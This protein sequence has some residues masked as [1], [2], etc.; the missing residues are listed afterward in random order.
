MADNDFR[1]AFGAAFPDG[2]VNS[3]AQPNKAV[4]R[5]LGPLIDAALAALASLIGSGIQWKDPVAV[6]TT[7]NVTLSGEQTIDGVQTSA[8]RVLVK[9]QTAPAQ[10]GI[11]VTG[12][13]AWGR[14]ADADSAAEIKG[15]AVFV[16][17]GTASK[18]KQFVCLATGVISLGST[19]LPYV[20][21]SDQTALNAAIVDLQSKLAE[22]FTAN[23]PLIDDRSNLIGLGPSLY[24]P[25]SLYVPGTLQYDL[26]SNND[27]LASWYRVAVPVTNENVSVYFD[28]QTN[29]V[30][31]VAYP[32]VNP[33]DVNRYYH[34]ISFFGGDKGYSTRLRY[35]ST[36]NTRTVIVGCDTPIVFDHAAGMLKVPVVYGFT[37]A[38]GPW[39]LQPVIE[40]DGYREIPVDK[41]PADTSV[42][43]VWIDVADLIRNGPRS[44]TAL[45][46]AKGYDATTNPMPEGAF[47]VFLGTILNETFH[48]APSS[49]SPVAHILP[50]NCGS[51][52]ADNDQASFKYNSTRPVDLKTSAAKSMGFTRAFAASDVESGLYRT[53]YGDCFDTRVKSGIVYFR[54]YI[55]TD[56]EGLYGDGFNAFAIDVNDSASNR[57]LMT[58]IKVRSVRKIGTGDFVREFEGWYRLPPGGVNA[59]TFQGCWI[60]FDT[61]VKDAVR[62]FGL[63]FAWSLDG[64]PYVSLGDYPRKSSTLGNRLRA[65][66]SG[67][68]SFDSL[69]EPVIPD[70]LYLIDGREY[71]LFPAQMIDDIAADRGRFRF[72]LSTDPVGGD[73]RKP[74]NLRGG[75]TS[76]LV[77]KPTDFENQ[78]VRLDFI[79][80]YGP[81]G[82]QKSRKI[83]VRKVPQDNII[84][85]TKKVLV[86][87][88]SIG[89]WNGSVT[90]SIHRLNS[91]GAAITTIGTLEMRGYIPGD[92][93]LLG[94]ARGGKEFSDFIYM[95]T[96][97]MSPVTNTTAGVN[98][99]LA[100]ADEGEYTGKRMKNPFVRPSTGGDPADRI[101]NGYIFDMRF[102]LNR[103]GFA[104]PD[105]VYIG[106]GTNDIS[107]QYANPTLALQQIMNGVRVMT[108]Q[109]RAALPNAKIIFSWHSL[110]RNEDGRWQAVHL[111]FLRSVLQYLRALND[112]NVYVLP[113]YCSVNRDTGHAT[114]GTVDATG[115]ETNNT[116]DGIHY[117]YS[118][119]DQFAEISAAFFA[120][121]L[122]NAG[123]N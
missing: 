94:E 1:N 111:K 95:D 112:P 33:V 110:G 71:T 30:K 2:P 53:Y 116:Y 25:R 34:I 106:L 16:R 60:G 10:N 83:K 97:H 55:E 27:R 89:D 9:N 77:L 49:H 90:R 103:F 88:D 76:S 98:A 47:C 50:N 11:Y 109:T 87:A 113:A 45:H 72:A 54:F 114:G 31:V 59:Q 23:G 48:P 99:Y 117:N 63:Q 123:G 101:F 68:A 12:A 4:I 121:V 19:P 44:P 107:Q 69:F 20:E 100:L 21:I 85:L 13:G 32:N 56:L 122:T 28:L 64:F 36:G 73:Y 42:K 67:G 24:I 26:P 105:A 52:A 62:I 5:S 81:Q 115:L 92:P 57:V 7:G 61:T 51:G 14:A 102:Y 35:Q 41:T 18:G 15:M 39:L 46:A 58:P 74:V 38:G 79:D 17:G 75:S 6:A 82:T 93:S 104:D 3:P 119:I 91:M 65:L 118:G 86:I 108:A 8:S 29:T 22:I 37:S 120:G 78:N 43:F 70:R 84:G 40:S 80:L 66:E 96:D